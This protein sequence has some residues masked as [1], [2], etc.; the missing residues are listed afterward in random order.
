MRKRRRRSSRSRA[1]RAPH[2]LR[3]PRQRH[4]VHHLHH[5]LQQ[6]QQQKR[7]LIH[8]Q[9][10]QQKQN[11]MRAAADA[12]ADQRAASGP[13]WCIKKNVNESNWVAARRRS[14]SR[15]LVCRGTQSANTLSAIFADAIVR[16]PEG[17]YRRGRGHA[18]PC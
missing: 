14:G 1:A 4:H 2:F 15:Y 18:A 11:Q 7:N 13:L 16:K 12:A 10:Q 3:H 5:R 9:R 8:K 17:R 6:R